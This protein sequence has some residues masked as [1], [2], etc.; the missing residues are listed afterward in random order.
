[1]LFRSVIALERMG[2]HRQGPRTVDEDLDAV[3]R[4]RGRLAFRPAAGG[5]SE[6]AAPPEPAEP[7]RVVRADAIAD[8]VAEPRFRRD[9][10]V[11]CCPGDPRHRGGQ[12]RRKR[13]SLIEYSA[14]AISPA[15]TMP[16]RYGPYDARA[17]FASAPSIP[18]ALPGL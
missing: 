13:A 15:A 1:M 11:G 10:G 5:R 8:A 2:D 7:A 6:R 16:S 14:K 3:A 18:T 12:T 4:A 9:H 17:S